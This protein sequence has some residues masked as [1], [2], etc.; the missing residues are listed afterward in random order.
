MHPDPHVPFPSCECGCQPRRKLVAHI[1]EQIDQGTYLTR[2]K[3]ERAADGLARD[4]ARPG[5]SDQER[6]SSGA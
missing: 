1:R 5:Q 4:L 6:L 3:L 2:G